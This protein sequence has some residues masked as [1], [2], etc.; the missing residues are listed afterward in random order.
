MQFS[1]WDLHKKKFTHNAKS[2]YTALTFFKLR[3]VLGW[4]KKLKTADM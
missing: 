4:N 1:L 2:I 3:L